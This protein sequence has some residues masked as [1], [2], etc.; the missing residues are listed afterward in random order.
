MSKPQVTI[1]LGRSGQVV[2][3]GGKR[4]RGGD[5]DDG[6]YAS[7][8]NKRCSSQLFTAIYFFVSDFWLRG[9]GNKWN[10]GADQVNGSQIA[11]NDLRLK[12][13]RKRASKQNRNTVGE[14]R[15]SSGREM[16]FKPAN[17]TMSSYM[18]PHRQDPNGSISRKNPHNNIS[19]DLHHV[20]SW[21]NFHP[22]QTMGR[23]RTGSPERIFRSSS[24]LSPSR[25]VDEMQKVS[26]MRPTDDP[27][28][29][30]P[31]S[32]E[33]LGHSRHTGSIPFT[34]K[35]PAQSG[36]PLSRAAP[37]SGIV[38]NISHTGEGALTVSG[39]LNAL[40]LGKYAIHFQ[41]EEVDMTVL[42]Q[43]R[44]VDLKEMGIPMG[45]RK[46]ILLALL[47]RQKQQPSR[48]PH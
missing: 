47:P 13:N 46:K 42:R 1:T 25:S 44:D 5:N 2:T 33:V 21:G 34:M 22:S 19:N 48:L 20:D 30:R 6:Y 8:A 14:H 36:N 40:G 41:A 12:L 43:M 15:K 29:G 35:T 11:Q 18:L 4:S 24:V 3:K 10:P 45:P 17:P 32:N 38:Q 37:T 26:W 23:R 7:N 28:G 9:N 16:L 27:R 31:F 39:F